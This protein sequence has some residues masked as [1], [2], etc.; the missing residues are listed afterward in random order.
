MTDSPNLRAR[1]REAAM[2]D[3]TVRFPRVARP[4]DVTDAEAFPEI[5]AAIAWARRLRGAEINPRED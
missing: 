2:R 4:V 3:A 1:I 5:A